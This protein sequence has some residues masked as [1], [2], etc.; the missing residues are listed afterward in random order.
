MNLNI[1]SIITRFPIMIKLIFIK[2]TVKN[3]F[4]MQNMSVI[5]S[6]SHVYD[7][8]IT[9]TNHTLSLKAVKEFIHSKPTFDVVVMEIFVNEAMLGFAE[10]FNAPVIGFSTFGA[11]KWTTDLV[12]TPSPPSYVPHPFLSFKDR[13]SFTER[14]GNTAMA[15]FEEIYMNY[16]YLPRQEELLRIHFPHLSKS[17]H[18][19][20]KN[21]NLVLLNSH[22]TLSYPRPYLPNMIEVGGL[23]IKKQTKPLPEVIMHFLTYLFNIF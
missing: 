11:S 2:I 10:S 21:V 12:G 23:H 15:I 4:E 13:M 7:M 22:V 1:H 5:D 20:R 9:I 16:F 8:G 14:F 19:L 3:L 17:L 18:E 6:I